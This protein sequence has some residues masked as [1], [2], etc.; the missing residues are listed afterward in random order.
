MNL[1]L[2]LIQNINL[3][4]C[5][6]LNNAKLTEKELQDLSYQFLRS[7]ISQNLENKKSKETLSDYILEN[8]QA[9]ESLDPMVLI[10]LIHTTNCP[11]LLSILSD[12]TNQIIKDNVTQNNSLKKS[13]ASKLTKNELNNLLRQYVDNVKGS[14]DILFDYILECPE[15]INTIDDYIII[16]W[17]EDIT[18]PDFIL[19]IIAQYNNDNYILWNVAKNKNTSNK[20]LK[21]LLNKNIKSIDREMA[22]NES[23]SSDLLSILANKDDTITKQR[24]AQNENIDN[25]TL[26]LLAK[27]K[28]FSVRQKVAKNPKITEEIAILLSKDENP[29]VRYFIANNEKFSIN[30]DTSDVTALE[31]KKPQQ[32]IQEK[33]PDNKDKTTDKVLDNNIPTDQQSIPKNILTAFDKF[34]IQNL[35]TALKDK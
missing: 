9:Q 25:E 21:Y 29:W 17:S 12:N 16:Q 19:D 27:D 26:E 18:T 33:I 7:P 30:N 14:K 3:C 20:T 6:H 15:E 10:K 5:Q 28:D 23:I 11:R 2:K 1:R 35:R 8:P 31:V 4:N 13:T 22:Y 32:E 24:V 34:I